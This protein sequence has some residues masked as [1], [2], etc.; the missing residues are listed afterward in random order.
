LF[1]R[2]RSQVTARGQTEGFGYEEPTGARRIA[3]RDVNDGHAALA[4]LPFG[5]IEAI[6]F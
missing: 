6:S 2:L 1:R 3:L 5:A 4:S